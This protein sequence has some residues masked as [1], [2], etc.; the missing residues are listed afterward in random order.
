MG[1]V[2]SGIGRV[3]RRGFQMEAW[4]VPRPHELP[5]WGV[6]L[7]R[8]W[9]R[10][11]IAV[12]PSH[13]AFLPFAVHQ[14]PSRMVA[15]VGLRPCWR[16]CRHPLGGLLDRGVAAQEVSKKGGV[17]FQSF[18]D[19]VLSCI[20]EMLFMESCLFVFGDEEMSFC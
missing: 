1:L 15:N 2:A 18:S 3:G 8:R 16:C 12:S 9:S 19:G 14:K 11:F 10:G 6:T 7:A 5:Y 4:W 17:S 13:R 20:A